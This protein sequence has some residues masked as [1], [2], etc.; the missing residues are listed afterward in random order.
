MQHK[1][2]DRDIVRGLLGRGKLENIKCSAIKSAGE[3]VVAG[4]GRISAVLNGWHWSSQRQHRVGELRAYGE[5][6]LA[7]SFGQDRPLHNRQDV[8]YAGR[9]CN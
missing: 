9:I 5:V 8:S 6:G 7:G 3:A 4:E 2:A 1:F